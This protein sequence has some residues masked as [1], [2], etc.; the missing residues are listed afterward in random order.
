MLFCLKRLNLYNMQRKTQSS[1]RRRGI[2]MAEL[3]V[4]MAILGI[5]TV[6][7]SQMMSDQQKQTRALSEKLA[8]LDLQSLLLKI[9]ADPSVCTFDLTNTVLPANPGNPQKFTD[10]LPT[11]ISPIS[12]STIHSSAQGASPPVLVSVGSSVN[13]S[14]K[15]GSIRIANISKI[16]TKQYLGELQITF[17][18]TAAPMKPIT[19]S[20]TLQTDGGALNPGKETIT[21]CS[22]SAVSATI[23]TGTPCGANSK[24]ITMT[25]GGT[26]Y[27]CYVG[28]G[29]ESYAGGYVAFSRVPC[30][31]Y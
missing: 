16:A 12:L 27:C 2:G 14:L 25:D 31:P 10:T 8:A 28:G 19:S 23:T 30:L 6:A 5:V 20:I 18:G 1:F 7:F 22:F 11:A 15:I 13:S 24:G 26:R 9:Y 3:L 21:G 4:A 29:A 17:T